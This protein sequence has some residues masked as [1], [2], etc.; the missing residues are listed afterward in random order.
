MTLAGYDLD[1]E[2]FRKYAGQSLPRHVAYPMPTWWRGVAPAEAREIVSTHRAEAARDLSLYLHVP[3]CQQVCRYC[4]CNRVGVAKDDPTAEQRTDAYVAA[5]QRE[6]TNW[7]EWLGEQ[8][9]VRQIHWG[10]GTPTY[11]SCARLTEVHGS[12]REHFDLAPD[13]EIAIECDP[14]VTTRAV[15]E[16]LRELGFTRISLGIQDFNAAVQEHVG[17]IQPFAQV[18][19]MVATIRDLGFPSINFDLIYGLPKQTTDTVRE[20]L[21]LVRELQPDRIAYYQFAQ[22]PDKVAEQRGLDY[23][24]LPDST[25]KL[26]MYLLGYRELTAAGYEFIGLDHF[27]LPSEGLARALRDGTLQRNFQGMT[28][29]G[30]LDLIG[31]GASSIGQL[32]RGAYLQNHRE[33]DAYQN[34]IEQ[35]GSAIFRGKPLSDD[36]RIRQATLAELYCRGEIRPAAIETECGI[37]FADY[38][39]RELE[40]MR[41]LEHDGL[42]ELHSDGRIAA[43]FPL[44]RV[45]LRTVAAVFDAYL[46][47]DAWRSGDRQY[48]STNA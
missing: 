8:R 31:V 19:E 38:F 24:S 37:R 2:L 6:L 17:R 11:L 7:G 20:T 21:D 22:I 26:E 12:I 27:A 35:G 42:V 10:G 9:T 36:D 33:I 15:L 45:L 46:D 28:T 14:R 23:D 48:F 39:A 18:R 3:F 43:A 16:T 47:P 30:G 25:T 5:L 41:T 32:Y 4:A 13:A 44:G 29:G 34:E 1:L 40:I